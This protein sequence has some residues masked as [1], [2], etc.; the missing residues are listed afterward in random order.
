MDFLSTILVAAP[1]GF[2]ANIILGLKVLLKI[3]R[4][5]NIIITLIIKTILLPFDL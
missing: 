5:T 3:M 4:C 1:T 2:W